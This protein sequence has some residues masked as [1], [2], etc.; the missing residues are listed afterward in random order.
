MK[1]FECDRGR[2]ANGVMDLSGDVRGEKFSVRSEAMV[3]NRCGAHVLTDQQSG[4]YTVAI[5]D[6]YRA[7]HG[8]LTSKD[9]KDIR[10]RLGLSQAAFARFL[11][12]GIASVKRWE[13]GLIQ[14]EAH[15][16]LIRLRTDLAEARHNVE[17]LEQRLE[18]DVSPGKPRVIEL[19]IRPNPGTSVW[20]KPS[21]RGIAAGLPRDLSYTA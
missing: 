7:K 20:D 2:L 8:L 16:Q 11:R 17:E 14:D 6:V 1:C 3:C 12:V 4:A 18:A 21:I 15:D 13:A 5:S 10:A 19:S 9:L